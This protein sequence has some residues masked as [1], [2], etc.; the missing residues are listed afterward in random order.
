M[1]CNFSGIIF[2]ALSI[3]YSENIFSFGRP[4]HPC[5]IS[6]AD[7]FRPTTKIYISDEE[8]R[9]WAA[10]M[11]E[12]DTAVKLGTEKHPLLIVVDNQ[13]FVMTREDR[14]KMRRL[15]DAAFISSDLVPLTEFVMRTGKFASV[16]PHFR[17]TIYPSVKIEDVSIRATLESRRSQLES[18]RRQLELDKHGAD[19]SR[20]KLWERADYIHG[21]FLPTPGLDSQISELR[22]RSELITQQLK[23]IDD[24]LFQIDWRLGTF[25]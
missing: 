23:M 20:N 21:W 25:N 14:E 6:L 9:L 7:R 4:P 11:S 1:R 15:S 8:S 17:P 10:F 2:F 12:V 3:C 5:A 24:E 16:P 18:E 13:P 22:T 19:S